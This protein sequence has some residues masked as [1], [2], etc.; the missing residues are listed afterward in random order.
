M[1][2]SVGLTLLATAAVLVAADPPVEA[3][4]K[5]KGRLQGTWVAE[6]VVIKGK[7]QEKFKGAM[8]HFSGDKVKSEFDG[9]KQEGTY[10]IDPTKNPEHIDLAHVRDGHN[11]LD[12]RLYE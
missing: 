11:K 6:S 12:R 5:E 8:F 10:A 2:V 9:K 7:A 3:V 4:K 1:K